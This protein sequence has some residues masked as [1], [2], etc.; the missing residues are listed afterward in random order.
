MKKY[1]SLILR[2]VLF[3]FA[4]SLT[5]VSCKSKA[6]LLEGKA[7][8]ILSA[9]KVIENHYNNKNEFSTLYIKANAKYKDDKMSQNVTAEIKI[10]KD[11]K[12]LVS[13]RFLGFTM[14]KA[15]IT[16][17][18]VQYYEK[19]NGKYFEGD[20]NGLSE[21]LGTD[22]DY[23]KV[24]N[25]LL[26]KAIDDLHKS[27]YM[28]SIMDKLYKLEN[29]ADGNTDKSF[30]F[31]ADNFLIKKQKV[32]QSQQD[33]ELQIVYPDYKKYNEMILPLSFVIDATQKKG[34]TNIN[35]DYKNVSFNEEL[36]FPY[37]V[38]EGYERIYIDKI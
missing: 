21:W 22:L 35:I 6:A 36:S 32:F 15:L 20:Y 17:T 19:I 16:P 25:M 34:Q 3:C 24:Q 26:G 30:F 37:S 28:V 9:D 33:R 31:E 2:V 23:T 13:I 12:I 1:L 18:S 5:L 8:G 4:S 14:A 27:N 29:N 11:E 10:K 38:P 7:T